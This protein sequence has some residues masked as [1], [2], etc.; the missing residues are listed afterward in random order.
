MPA[1]ILVAFR[2]QLLG[3]DPPSSPIFVFSTTNTN[4]V[5]EMR[6]V[7]VMNTDTVAHEFCIYHVPSGVTPDVDHARF[8][9]VSIAA[10]TSYEIGYTDGE[11]ILA[12]G[13]ELWAYADTADV[14][15]VYGSGIA[16]E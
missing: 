10:N 16:Y 15:N 2:Q 9:D 3:V 14:V 12:A 1:S 4:A 11:W 8:F 13:D 5:F 6:G 7:S